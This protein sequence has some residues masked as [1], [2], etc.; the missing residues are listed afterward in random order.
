MGAK[1][2]LQAMNNPLISRAPEN[3]D[4]LRRIKTGPSVQSNQ[5]NSQCELTQFVVAWCCMVVLVCFGITGRP[6]GLWKTCSHRLGQVKIFFHSF[7]ILVNITFIIFLI[8]YFI[9][10]FFFIFS[11]FTFFHFF[12]SCFIIFAS[13]GAKIFQEWKITIFLEFFFHCFIFFSFF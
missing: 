13:S 7:I 11:F 9:I 10:L 8:I 5:N 12:L 1:L 4:P 2:L 6:L 3:G